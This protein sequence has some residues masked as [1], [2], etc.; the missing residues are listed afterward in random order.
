MAEKWKTQDSAR[1]MTQKYNSLVEEVNRTS[2]NSISTESISISVD[3]DLTDG[4]LDKILRK[5]KGV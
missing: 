1:T 5:N 3:S 4:E 2:S